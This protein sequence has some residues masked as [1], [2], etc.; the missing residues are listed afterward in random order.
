MEFQS[1]I[2]FINT[3]HHLAKSN[4]S[5][6]NIYLENSKLILSAIP[7]IAIMGKKNTLMCD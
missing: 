7:T 3:L 2:N 1:D 4:D 5:P 6:V